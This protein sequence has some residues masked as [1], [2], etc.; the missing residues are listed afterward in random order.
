MS[1]RWTSII[2]LFISFLPLSLINAHEID[3]L[4]IKQKSNS[5]LISQNTSGE[6]KVTI[7]IKVSESKSSGES[8]DIDRSVID[9]EPQS[10]GT[11]KSL[12]EKPDIA[13]CIQDEFG[14]NDCIPDHVIKPQNIR[15]ARCEDKYSCNFP[16]VTL[17]SG[18]FKVVIV[19][20]DFAANDL[21]GYGNCDLNSE[22]QVGQATIKISAISE[23][24][25]GNQ[26]K[27]PELPSGL[28]EAEVNQQARANGFPKA[29][30]PYFS[31]PNGCGPAN[32]WWRY[33]VTPNGPLGAYYPNLIRKYLVDG[34]DVFTFK[35]SCN[36]HDICYISGSQKDICDRELYKALQF[37]CSPLLPAIRKECF[38]TAKAFYFAVTSKTSK[39]SYQ[40][41]S[42]NQKEYIIF[43][44][45]YI[46]NWQKN[47]PSSA[48]SNS[49]NDTNFSQTSPSRE[50]N[51]N[52]SLREPLWSEP[53]DNSNQPLREPLWGEPEDAPETNEFSPPREPLF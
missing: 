17:P 38:L 44:R 28:T 39:T 8:W 43:L 37:Q 29:Q 52:E 25:I 35:E 45:Q 47:T 32:S 48:S 20:V 3:K 2:G 24:I 5:V 1:Y 12:Y 40:S 19:D 42:Q 18:K 22:C 30:Y 21:I 9:I 46:D 49:S 41:A 7:E 53:E 13:I 23:N 10:G 11:I 4:L 15:H 26:N 27:V 6:R 51:S 36:N 50:N 14:K 16:S 34:K 31:R 33:H